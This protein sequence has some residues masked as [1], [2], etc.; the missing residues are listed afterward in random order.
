MSTHLLIK[1]ERVLI[2][3]G[4]DFPQKKERK[5]KKKK[6]GLDYPTFVINKIIG[7]TE[8]NMFYLQPIVE[9]QD[10]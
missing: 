5:E 3:I 7:K 2:L 10:F 1:K 8:T 4:L 9:L 6:K